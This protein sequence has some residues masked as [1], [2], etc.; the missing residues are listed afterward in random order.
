MTVHRERTSETRMPLRILRPALDALIDP[1]RCERTMA[2][3]LVAYAMVW[4]L[5]PPS[6]RAARICTSISARCSPGRTSDLERADPSA[7]WRL[8]DAAVVQRRCRSKTELVILLGLCVATVAL[9]IASPFRGTYRSAEKRVVG[10]LLLTWLPFYNFHALKYN[11]SSVL[12][13]FWAATTWWFLL[14]YRTRR[15]GWAVLA[16][17]AAAAAMLGKYW[18]ILLLAGLALGALSDPRRAAYFRSPAPWLTMAAGAIGLAPHVIFIA[19]HHFSTV[20]FAMTAHETTFAMAFGWSLY[21]LASVLG[22]IAAP[23][24]LSALTTYPSLAA[25]RDLI[26]PGNHRAAHF[27]RD[28]CCAGHSCCRGCGRGARPPRSAMD[29]L[30]HDAAAGGAAGVAFAVDRPRGGHPPA[31]VGDCVSAAGAGGVSG[32]GDRHSQQ[33]RAQLRVPIQPDRQSGRA[34][35]ERAHRQAAARRRQ[36]PHRGRWQQSVLPDPAGD[37]RHHQP[38]AHALGR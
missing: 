5:T 28:L 26:W 25:I 7:A 36:L 9:W 20:S 19:T 15:S 34:G 18:S 16:G 21:F 33:W 8:A 6:P 22:Y 1:A 12:T 17:V 32:R 23:V 35:V 24:V 10:T 11:A 37:L 29:D 4:T 13:P 2:R 3:L 31:G 27:H 14:W 38:M 30:R